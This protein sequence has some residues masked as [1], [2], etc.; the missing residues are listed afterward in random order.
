MFSKRVSIAVIGVVLCLLG[1]SYFSVEK[2]ASSSAN[3]SLFSKDA[4]ARRA[5]VR[6]LARRHRDEQKVLKTQNRSELKAWIAK[7]R[8]ARRQF[9]GQNPEGS[10]KREYIQDYI[11]RRETLEAELARKVNALREKQNLERKELL[12]KQSGH[13]VSSTIPTPIVTPV[14]TPAASGAVEAPATAAV[15]SPSH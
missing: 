9:F 8:D 5:E 7:E 1:V 13:A 14:A 3:A 15:S 11:Q 12:L 2:T 6:R 10:K 4:F